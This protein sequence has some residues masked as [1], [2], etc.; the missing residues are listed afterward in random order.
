MTLSGR[1]VALNVVFELRD[2]QMITPDIMRQCLGEHMSVKGAIG[3][4]SIEDNMGNLDLENVDW[5]AR[6]NWP[7]VSR[8]TGR[9]MLPVVF[10]M[11][12]SHMGT[13]LEGWRTTTGLLL[14]QPMR[15]RLDFTPALVKYFLSKMA[16]VLAGCVRLEE[17]D[18]VEVQLAP[19]SL[20]LPASRYE[21]QVKPLR[22]SLAGNPL[23]TAV[24]NFLT[25]F[26]DKDRAP[27]G[28]LEAWTSRMDAQILRSGTLLTRRMDIMISR[29][30]A[31]SAGPIHL[32][33]WGRAAVQNDEG[34]DMTLAIF[35][36]T[37]ALVGIKDLPDDFVLRIHVKGSAIAP[38]VQFFKATRHVMELL[39]ERNLG[40]VYGMG[41]FKKWL[42]KRRST[43]VH[44][45]GGV[46]EPAKP[47]PWDAKLLRQKAPTRATFQ[48]T[49]LRRANFG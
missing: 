4:A 40:G 14:R 3:S 7:A 45:Y 8:K 49:D 36:D 46:P 1:V 24:L 32:A 13:I 37:M 19:L 23:V 44:K 47:F 21:V 16:P 27:G 18:M 26:R 30:F 9:P 33:M 5:L 48:K 43:R 28:A 11:E 20:H 41:K 31:V 22:L 15:L 42:E 10:K 17:D 34:L 25:S 12:A 38:Q 39:F 6:D 35:Q 2:G 29:S